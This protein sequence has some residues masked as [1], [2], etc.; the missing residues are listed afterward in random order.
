MLPA[1]PALVRCRWYAELHWIDAVVGAAVGGYEIDGEHPRLGGIRQEA[2]FQS[3]QTLREV[4]G[5]HIRVG[6]GIA[7]PHFR[8]G[9]ASSVRSRASN[10][11]RAACP[12]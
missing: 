8:S 10:A 11:P 9:A 5:T 1:P 12:R 7:P 3:F 2:A 4:L 6:G